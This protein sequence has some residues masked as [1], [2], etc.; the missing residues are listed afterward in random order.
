M[1][2]AMNVA[3]R[4]AMRMATRIAN[5]IMTMM[6]ATIVG[7]GEGKDKNRTYKLKRYIE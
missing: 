3:M 1:T 6:T 4:M 5:A 2:A 7:I